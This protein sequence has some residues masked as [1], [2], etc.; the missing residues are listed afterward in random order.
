MP[1]EYF[2]AYHSYLKAMEL[3]SDAEAGRLYRALLRYSET[4]EVADLRGNE[5][6]VFASMQSQIDRDNE[7]YAERCKKNQENALQ[8]YAN[9]SER[10][11]SHANAAKEKEK[12]KEKENIYLDRFSRFWDRYP[13]KVA[14]QEAKKA[15]LKLKPDEELLEEI[16][17]AIHEQKKQEQWKNKQYIPNPATWLNR[18]QWEDEIILGGDEPDRDNWKG[19]LPDL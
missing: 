16:L 10:M 9:A 2:C 7:K 12:E 3:L 4:G 17:S 6:F 15:F 13:K 14:K 5:R 11:Q 1:R 8:R 18:R 19:G